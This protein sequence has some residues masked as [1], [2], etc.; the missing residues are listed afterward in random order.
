M[1]CIF[2]I[3]KGTGY[4]LHCTSSFRLEKERKA[5]EYSTEFEKYSLPS[6]ER[7]CKSKLPVSV[8]KKMP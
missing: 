1:I 5:A 8:M 3:F 6:P 4:S 7:N 2:T